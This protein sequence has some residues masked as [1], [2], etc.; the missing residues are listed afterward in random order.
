MLNKRKNFIT[1]NQYIILAFTATMGTMLIVFLCNQMVPFGDKTILRMDLY[2]QYGPLFAELYERV[3]NGDSLLYSWTSGLGSCFLGN[4]FNY[5]SSPIGAVVLFF[6]HKNITEAIATMILIKASL[7]AATF[8]YYL[9]K[10][11]RNQSYA[12]VCFGILYAFCGYMLAYYWNVMWL[13][14]MVLLPIVLY[15]I[16]KI[17]NSGKIGTYTFALALTMFSNYY[18]SFMICIFSCIYFFYYFIIRYDKDAVVNRIYAKTHKGFFAKLKNNRFLRSGCAFAVGSFVA[19]GLMAVV[20]LPVYNVLQQCSATSGNFPDDIKTYFNYF[21]F[22]ANH[23]AALTT[24]IRSSGDDVLPNIY[25]GI[26]PLILAPFFFFSKTISKKEKLATIGLL[27]TLYFSF[28]VNVFNFIWHGFH[29]PNDLP[30]RQ[31]FIYSFVLLVMSF[32]AFIRLKEFRARDYGI[33]GA[34]L[35]AFVV[36]VDEL[37]SKNVTAATVLF[38]MI[39][40]ILYVLII[41]FFKD[42]RYQTASLAMLLVVCTCSEVIMCDTAS[43]NIS[44]DKTPYVSDYDEF[45]KL[46]TDLDTIENNK[47]YRMELTDLR[48]RMDN[49]WYYYN[50]AS[51]FSS[52][53]YEKLSNLQ[54]DL[55]MMSNRINSYT[56][57]PQTPV[58]NA[59]FSLKYIVNNSSVNVLGSDY[60]TESVST[61]KFKAYKNNY[62]LP[63]AYLISS[64]A[65]TWGSSS[66]MDNWKLEQ[67]SDPFMLQG[68]YFS[69]ATGIGNP[70]KKLDISYVTY[71]NCSPFSEDLTSK[72]F[73]YE[74]NTADTD[75]NATF[76]ITTEKEGN[77]YIYVEVSSASEKSLTI[78]T[79]KGVI[80]HSANQNCILDL[81]KYQAN[82]TVQIT[83]PFEANTGTVTMLA[84]TLNNKIFNK[85][86]KILSDNQM[87]VEEFD[88]TYI[89][90]RVT[91][92]TDSLLYTSIPYDDGWTVYIDGEKVSEL[93]IIKFGQ[94]LL[95][96]KV[97]EGNHT[98]E[99]RFEVE[100]LKTGAVISL[101]TLLAVLLFVL[102]KKIRNGKGNRFLP[103]FTI[104]NNDYSEDI[105]LTEKANKVE[106]KPVIISKQEKAEKYI[107]PQREIIVP[108]F[109]K[110]IKKEIIS[111][112]DCE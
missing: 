73:Y 60:Y 72:S 47:F 83:V 50:G 54:D 19:A 20:L 40:V 30:Y 103:A 58:Y 7:S 87:L 53:A 6:G 67:S 97:K 101:V 26:L 52:M 3:T 91:A 35:L 85:G 68:D 89:R 93:D 42:K 21:D 66:Y 110:E 45:T 18:M 56:Y 41:S 43:L 92:E 1:E 34:A 65:E 48:T 78:N 9:K 28:N 111:P 104:E 74:K 61:D 71:S 12:G 33:A 62:Y 13:D 22:L 31:S 100:G 15:G 88:D 94:S 75:A 17:I 57:N 5:L 11:Q 95:S 99:F 8:T 79:S 77:V 10:S 38:T 37:T 96:V 81:G 14:A 76:Y 108:D 70:F 80:T 55:G 27:A 25:C 69:M 46:K 39:L 51:V 86:Y 98:V 49:S 32:K 82:E 63:I 36:I 23:L 24:T 84:Y 64:D 109:S 16:E 112:P 4:Y 105:F 107:P 2:H 44:V 106:I 90:G 29:F 59:M 102:L